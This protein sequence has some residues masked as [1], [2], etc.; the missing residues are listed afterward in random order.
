M[1][2]G[3]A[4]RQ[5]PARALFVFALLIACAAALWPAAAAAA[6][7]NVVLITTDDQTAASYNQVTMPRTVR[8]LSRNGAGFTDAIVATP[9]CCPSRATMITGQYGFNHGVIA[10]DPG[11]ALLEQKANTLPVWLS[12][13]GYTTAHVGKYLNRYE[14]TE[15]RD[16]APGWD[17]WF[18]ILAAD[19]LKPSYSV[20]GKVRR[21][22]E[23]EYVTR[24]LSS[25][26]AKMIAGFSEQDRPFY[27]QL[28]QLAP[29]I[30]G[31]A[32]PGRC[33]D[34]PTPDPRRDADLFAGLTV[35]RTDAFNE[36]DVTDKP[37]FIQAQPPLTDR[38]INAL[39]TYY[40]CALATL[41]AVDRG[42]AKVVKVLR[43]K[44]ELENTL[45]IFT[46]DNG[47]SFGDHRV[48]ETKGLPYEEH[49]RVPLVIRPPQR[50][51]KTTAGLELES[52]VSN[53]DLAPTILDYARAEPCRAEDSCRR[54]DGRS[55]RT[56]LGGKDPNWARG[57][58]IRVSFDINSDR[59]GLSC[60]WEGLRTSGSLLVE[61][62]SAPDPYAEG[63]CKP[64]SIWERYDLVADPFQL[65][66]LGPPDADPVA[67]ELA[68][69][70][71]LL[72]DC[73]GIKGRDEPA[74]GRAFC[75]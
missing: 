48:P 2:K 10:N 1:G 6:R 66:N 18:T 20:D 73:T 45:I 57:R 63:N 75:E 70:L 69:R 34:A 64:T 14:E 50:D 44:H 30:G 65:N 37:A 72:R 40:G 36:A 56:L 43:R 47:F 67:A 8:L 11:Y 39:D 26:A 15:G 31:A 17:H 68:A 21:A 25:V 28:D 24:R 41:R 71:E 9:Q 52:V 12:R 23:G 62:V 55:L 27:L 38:E 49:L 42:N 29:H 13:A 16:P 5:A 51:A 22:R 54:M 19:Y 7:P 46:S 61:H 59:Y 33:E 58:A 60:A 74:A 3:I 32:H 35:P 4:R 53:V